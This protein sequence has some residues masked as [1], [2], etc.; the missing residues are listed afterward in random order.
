M[1]VVRRSRCATRHVQTIRSHGGSLPSCG[2]RTQ[3]PDSGHSGSAL[4]A[5]AAIPPTCVQGL[6]L[7][8]RG[9]ADPASSVH[10]RGHQP[11]LPLASPFLLAKGTRPLR[12]MQFI[13]LFSKHAPLSSSLALSFSETVLPPIS[14]K[15]AVKMTFSLTA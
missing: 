10:G 13:C 12:G 15:E 2:S 14:I 3:A 6:L 7:W 1:A 11:N 5:G 8:A 4:K 9:C